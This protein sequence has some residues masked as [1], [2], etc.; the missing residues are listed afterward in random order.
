MAVHLAAITLLYVVVSFL[1][2]MDRREEINAFR[3]LSAFSCMLLI[4][5]GKRISILSFESTGVILI[6]FDIAFN[7]IVLSLM[8]A[9]D[10]FFHVQNEKHE[11]ELLNAVNRNELENLKRDIQTREAFASV[12][13]DLKNHIIALSGSSDDEYGEKLLDY[14]DSMSGS[15]HTGNNTLDGLIWSKMASINALGINFNVNLDLSVLG[16]LESIDVVALFGNLLDNAVEAVSKVQDASDRYIFIRNWTYADNMV[17]SFI[18]SRIG[19]GEEKAGF[20]A[21][22]KPDPD[23]HGIGMRNIRRTVEKYNGVFSFDNS[24]DHEFT[25]TVM[26]P[27]TV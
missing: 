25:A 3:F 22:S 13:H 4:V 9:I 8:V 14:L 11:A 23:N 17:I 19:K 5:L 15:L 24:K 20:L 18:N 16:Y 10:R 2:F 27:M 1:V 7:L 26:L 6:L 12:A 21:S